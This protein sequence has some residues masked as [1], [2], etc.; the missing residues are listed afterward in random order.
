MVNEGT[1]DRDFTVRT[2]CNNSATNESTV[3]V[4]TLERCF[5]EKFD[6]EVSN[7]VDTVEDRILNANLTTTDNIV[8]PKIELAIRS[9]NAPSG[10]NATSVVA[11]LERGEHVEVNVPFGNASGNK[12][13]QQVPYGKD[14]TRND[15]PD[16]VSELSVP[17]TRFDRQAHTRHIFRQKRNRNVRNQ[18]RQAENSSVFPGIEQRKEVTAFQKLEILIRLSLSLPFFGNHHLQRNQKLPR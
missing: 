16:D 1:N 6:R 3:N 14:E 13:V 12:K 10:R 7:I 11:N 8:A 4:K 2:S 5:S 15:I 17:E 18:K 9:I